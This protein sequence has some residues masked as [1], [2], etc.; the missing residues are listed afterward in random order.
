MAKAEIGKRLALGMATVWL[1]NAMFA[2][3]GGRPVIYCVF[4]PTLSALYMQWA[5]VILYA[6]L[7]IGIYAMWRSD[8]QMTAVVA[9]TVFTIIELPN[10]ADY[11]WRM[12]GSCA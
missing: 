10:L 3:I 12:G 2:V 9:L 6:V 11:L 4:E 1:I 5:I 8:L 7:L